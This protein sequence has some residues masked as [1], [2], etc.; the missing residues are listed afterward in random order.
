VPRVP[1]LVAASDGLLAR[2][3]GSWSKE[4]HHYL[5]RYCRIFSSGMKNLW[6]TRTYIDLFSGP[7]RCVIE[8][9]GEEIDGS[10]LIAARTEPPFTHL[11][12]NDLDPLAVEAL[13]TRVR[14]LGATNAQ[15]L[16]FDCNIV[17]DR[18]LAWL[19]RLPPSLDLCFIDPTAWQIRFTSVARLTHGRR[20]DL[21]IAFQSASMKRITHLDA[22]ALA[23]FFGDDPQYPEWRMLYETAKR[24]GRSITRTFLDHYQGRLRSIGYREFH[25]EVSV[26]AI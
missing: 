22:Q 6:P 10:P 20:M 4:K 19:G 26:L 8:G 25:D 2:P 13:D 14:A 12:Y 24:D 18:I 7:G 15:C 16:N 17:I 1:G 23:D 3:V 9:T 5:Q 21:I 11:F